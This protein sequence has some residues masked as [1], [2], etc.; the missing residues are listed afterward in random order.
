MSTIWKTKEG[1]LPQQKRAHSSD[2][3][4]LH[5]IGKPVGGLDWLAD[6]IAKRTNNINPFLHALLFSPPFAE[7]IRSGS[8]MYW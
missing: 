3:L 4:S 7:E 1:L 8:R 2:R 5:F 6:F